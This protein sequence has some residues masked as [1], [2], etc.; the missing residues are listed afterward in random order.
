MTD[1]VCVNC[2]MS[3]EDVYLSAIRDSD[4]KAFDEAKYVRPIVVPKTRR[5]EVDREIARLQKLEAWGDSSATLARTLADEVDTLRAENERIKKSA[6]YQNVTN[7]A[8]AV[9]GRDAVIT[10]LLAMLKP[11][12]SPPKSHTS[13]D[14]VECRCH[15]INE[16]RHARACEIA[17]RKE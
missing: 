2:A 1:G 8:L 11:G 3:F 12:V 17:G 14:C 13:C 7:F 10:K 9:A 4:A 15:K 16:E 5:E 6:E